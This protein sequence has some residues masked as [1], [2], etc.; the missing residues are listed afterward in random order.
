MSVLRDCRH[1]R[2]ASFSLG[3][4]HKPRQGAIGRVVVTDT[5]PNRCICPRSDLSR[6]VKARVF[7]RCGP[8]RN[9]VSGRQTYLTGERQFRYNG[10]VRNGDNLLLR[11]S[12]WIT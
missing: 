4:D 10:I 12:R 6:G 5:K 3:C 2:G 11:S 1:L 7:L 9:G 8:S